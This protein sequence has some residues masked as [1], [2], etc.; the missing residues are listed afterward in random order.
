MRDLATNGMTVIV[1]AHE[2]RFVRTGGDALVFMALG[3]IVEQGPAR[4][5]IANPRHERTRAFLSKVP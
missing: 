2:I 5:V 1:V 4:D 3:V